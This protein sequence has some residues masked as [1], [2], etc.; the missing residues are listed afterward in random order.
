MVNQK[1]EEEEKKE[2]PQAASKEEIQ[3]AT[4][5]AISQ[6]LS[7]ILQETEKHQSLME[8]IEGWTGTDAD[9][10]KIL[11]TQTFMYKRGKREELRE[12]NHFLLT[13]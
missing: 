8:K 1:K 5:S 13:T 3:Q 9:C 12:R 4:I 2:Q 6:N 11:S 7:V 10:A